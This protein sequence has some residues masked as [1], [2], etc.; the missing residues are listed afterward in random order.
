MK[1]DPYPRSRAYREA[2]SKTFLYESRILR[3]R[4]RRVSREIDALFRH[5]LAVLRRFVPARILKP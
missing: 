3:I 2:Y 4:L 5:D 1:R